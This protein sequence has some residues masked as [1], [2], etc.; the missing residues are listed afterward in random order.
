MNRIPDKPRIAILVGTSTD[1]GRRL[2]SGVFAYAK[3]AG[4]WDMWVPP[5]IRPDTWD[6]LRDW[7]CDGIITRV[8]K[9]KIAETITTLGRPIVDV[10]DIPIDG[11]SAPCVR[12]DDFFSA[13]MT[14]DHFQAR[15]IRNIAVPLYTPHPNSLRQFD[16]FKQAHTEQGLPSASLTVY[17]FEESRQLSSP[18]F[19][20]WLARQPKPLGVFC[21]GVGQGHRVLAACA[22]AH[23]CVP[24]DVSILCGDYDS[25]LSEACYP[26]LSGVVTPTKQIGYQSAKLLHQLMRG[27]AVSHETVFLPPTEL[28][29][30]MSTDTMAVKDPQIA[31]VARFIKENAL[32]NITLK[33]I[34]KEV[35]MSRRSLD[36]K[37]FDVFGRSPH[38]EIRRIR[39][40]KARDLLENTDMPIQLIA[41]AC[42][43]TSYT[44]LP[45]VFKQVTG[46]T[47]SAYRKKTRR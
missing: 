5:I 18:D 21:G 32:S 27:D 22:K 14:I 40:N 35:P 2:V 10:S 38:D 30:G 36:Q 29:N 3:E 17:P 31:K 45:N 12:T 46:M 8:Y 11:F 15:G 37:Y 13:R 47:P 43:Y 25:V 24:H 41:E 1:W 7:Q 4:S 20:D 26:S 6:Q 28:I 16:R 44:Y 9:K 23:L 39:I 33:D 34:L 19:L 42:G